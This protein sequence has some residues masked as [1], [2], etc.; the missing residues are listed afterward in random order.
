MGLGKE[1]VS[2]GLRVLTLFVVE[3]S[4]IQ[5]LDCKVMRLSSSTGSSDEQS[6]TAIIGEGGGGCRICRSRIYY[7]AFAVH[8]FFWAGGASKLRL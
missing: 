7:S 3:A 4:Q 6:G 1:G 8:T 2:L 5:D